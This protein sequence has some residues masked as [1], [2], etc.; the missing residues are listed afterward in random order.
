MAGGDL[1][2]HEELYQRVTA[3]GR[4]RRATG[5]DPGGSARFLMATCW[6]DG[7]P[8]DPLESGQGT[9]RES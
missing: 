9:W 3:L 6:G 1:P 7:D 2:Q 8:N 4:W 5:L